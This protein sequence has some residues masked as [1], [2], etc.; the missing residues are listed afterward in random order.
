VQSV[1]ERTAEATTT[2]S[3][4]RTIE[5]I[6]A[7]SFAVGLA[8]LCLFAWQLS[9]A[10]P[11][12]RD[13]P[14]LMYVAMLWDRFDLVPHVG[15]F[16]M[17]M[18][19]SYVS[20]LGIGRLFGYDTASTRHADFAIYVVLAAMTLAAMRY[21]GWVAGCVA[22]ALFGLI[23]LQYGPDMSLQR[24]YLM[25]VPLAAAAAAATRFDGVHR[26]MPALLAGLGVGAAMTIKPQAAIAALPISAFLGAEAWL[27][28]ER[29]I[30]TRS[31]V[32]TLAWMAAGI[33]AVAALLLAVLAELGALAAFFDI[34]SN[35]LPLY[36]DM[37]GRHQIF[38]P[39]QRAHYISV[40]W[41][42][43]GLHGAWLIAG[44]I[45][46]F[47]Y[48]VGLPSRDPRRRRVALFAGLAVAF[49]VYP[50]LSG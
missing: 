29:A 26:R 36:G 47:A 9:L 1:T 50:L 4:S 16:D 30:A 21:A 43:F 6:V 25:L 12:V 11:M 28:A 32:H 2:P 19:G 17:N 7:L 10:W 13:L 22:A 33:V 15:F 48:A 40:H 23:Y 45:G 37:S 27:S 5:T 20:Y 14:I 49:A 8:T 18:L 3:T 35:Y 24:E 31:A 39:G 44:A 42:R 34:A 46:A 38:E 41:P